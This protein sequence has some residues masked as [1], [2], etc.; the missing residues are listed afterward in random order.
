L[1]GLSI[2]V[3]KEKITGIKA[4]YNE[5]YTSCSVDEEE[6]T[7]SGFPAW[8]ILLIVVLFLI[9]LLF[10]VGTKCFGKYGNHEPLE[11]RHRRT[12]EDNEYKP[13]CEGLSK[14]LENWLN[15]KNTEKS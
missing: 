10:A 6:E 8:A 2:K 13:C 5:K 11:Q 3:N 7:G 4:L 15:K 1:T 14:A 9:F 12:D